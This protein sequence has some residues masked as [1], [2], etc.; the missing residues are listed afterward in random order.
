MKKIVVLI[1]ILV[2]LVG[3]IFQFYNSHYNLGNQTEK[4]IESLVQKSESVLSNFSTNIV[5][6]SNVTDKYKNDLAELIKLTLQGRYGEN[7]SQAVFQFLHEQN[8]APDSKMYL[9]IQNALI[10]GRAEFKTSQ[11]RI[12]D[13]CK[14]YKIELDSLVSGTML[15]LI[16][17]PKIDLKNACEIVSDEKT[18]E[19]FKTKNQKPII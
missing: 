14:Q 16:G 3:I 8:M 6:M 10:A 1:A 9:N 2:A 17:Y 18:K 13:V 7:G 5:E 11:E 15:R 4:N 19:I 12:V